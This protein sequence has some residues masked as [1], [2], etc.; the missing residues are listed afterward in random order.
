MPTVS[1]EKLELEVGQLIHDVERMERVLE[2]AEENNGK[3]TTICTEIKAMA[4]MQSRRL[5]HVENDVEKQKSNYNSDKA[6]F[7]RGMAR[8]HD[9]IESSEEKNERKIDDAV[10]KLSVKIDHLCDKSGKRI[11]NLTDRIDRFDKLKW[12]GAGIFLGLGVVLANF[13][14]FKTIISVIMGSP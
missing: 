11:D 12:I 9:K 13:P 3:L 8:L 10:D 4:Q 6:E 1:T 5:E 7:N 2:K 14:V